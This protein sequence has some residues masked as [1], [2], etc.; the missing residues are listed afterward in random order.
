MLDAQILIVGVVKNLIANLQCN[1]KELGNG[2]SGKL[3]VTCDNTGLTEKHHQML[4][5]ALVVNK[6]APC[7][8]F[9]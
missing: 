7:G 2:S 6:K 4:L 9:F 8:A 1:G 5:K 3:L